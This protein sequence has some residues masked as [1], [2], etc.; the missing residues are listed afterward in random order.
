MFNDPAPKGYK[1][2]LVPLQVVNRGTE[3]KTLLGE[4]GYVVGDGTGVEIG[5]FDP[6]CG[7]IPKELDQFKTV[8]PGGTLKGNMCFVVPTEDLKTL[9]MGWPTSFFGDE[10]DVELS[11]R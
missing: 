3:A 7:V 10:P 1:M 2:V 9:R 11:L 4:A 5:D 6:S 8:R